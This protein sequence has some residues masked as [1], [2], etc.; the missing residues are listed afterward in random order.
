MQDTLLEA[1]QTISNPNLIANE[2]ETEWHNCHKSFCEQTK[3]NN[4]A[5][6]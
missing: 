3:F 5:G 1:Y 4:T 2:E 6:T